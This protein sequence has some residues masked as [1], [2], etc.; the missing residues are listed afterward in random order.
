[1]KKRKNLTKQ[2][3]KYMKNIMDNIVYILCY[4]IKMQEL[5]TCK[6]NNLNFLQS[7]M[8]KVSV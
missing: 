7:I 5:Y 8:K 2:Q 6:R 3:L 4:I 1:M